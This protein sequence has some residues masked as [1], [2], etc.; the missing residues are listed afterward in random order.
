MQEG[1]WKE[2]HSKWMV[3]LVNGAIFCVPVVFMC[4]SL[5]L[6]YFVEVRRLICGVILNIKS[7]TYWLSDLKKT[8]YS[9]KPQ[10]S[11]W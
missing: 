2:W 7:T 4:K 10:C 8:T 3:A 6:H 11:H 9:Y 1:H 5:I